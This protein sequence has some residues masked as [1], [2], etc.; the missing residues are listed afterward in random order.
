MRAS[1]YAIFEPRVVDALCEALAGVLT[2]L[3][4]SDE[5]NDVS[6]RAATK[7]VELA[8]AG[9]RDPEK[10]KAETLKWLRH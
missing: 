6:D 4:G 5:A 1:V 2:A 8:K 3:G 7:I 9:V 10:L